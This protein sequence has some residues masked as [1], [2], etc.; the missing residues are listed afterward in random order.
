MFITIRAT[1]AESIVIMQSSSNDSKLRLD[2]GVNAF[3]VCEICKNYLNDPIFITCHCSICK[4]H[5]KDKNFIECMTHKQKFKIPMNGFAENTKAKLIIERGD[6][7]RIEEKNL[8]SKAKAQAILMEGIFEKVKLMQ[9]NFESIV[10]EHYQE[11]N[12]KIDKRKDL[13]KLEVDHIAQKL[14]AR[15]GDFKKDFNEK[16]KLFSFGRFEHFL[17]ENHKSLM[18]IFLQPHSLSIDEINCLAISQENGIIQ[19]QEEFDE[20]K[21]YHESLYKFDFIND[22]TFTEKCF[23]SLESP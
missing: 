1:K 14:H 17:T 4:H 23:G 6:H 19:L 11:I 9:E 21:R 12:N 5:V 16:L 3:L 10:N 2:L 7:L 20:L 18:S 13:V 8:Q 15:V 22:F